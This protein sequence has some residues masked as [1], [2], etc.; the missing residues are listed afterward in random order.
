MEN[1]VIGSDIPW[2]LLQER[3]PEISFLLSI[4]EPNLRTFREDLKKSLYN[5][6]LE[7]EL[8]EWKN[9]LILDGVEVLYVYGVG[10]GYHYLSLKKWLAEKKERMLVF[11]EEDLAVLQELFKLPQGLDLLQNPQVHIELL[12]KPFSW[13]QVLDEAIRK[14][15]SDR[16][17]FTSMISYAKGQEK[18]IKKIRLE[19]LRKSALMCV[20]M[21]E[22]LHYHRLMENISLNFLEV[23][24]SF[25]VN[26]W[27]NICRGVPAI[28]CGAGVS[29]AEAIET[30]K[31]LENKAL[32]IAGGS[33]IT[34]LN[35]VGIRPHIA[36]A[37]DP[38]DEEYARIKASSCFEIPFVYS[39]RLQ[40]EVLTSTNVTSGYL[41]SDTGGAFEKWL[42]D[43]LKIGGDTL[44]PELGIEALSVTT[45]AVPLA[46]YLGCGPIL[47]CGVDLSYKD[48][49]RYPEGVIASAKV[50]LEEMQAEKRSMEKLVR[51]KNLEGQMVYSLVKW[52]MEANCLGSYAKKN[53]GT[54]FFNAS[55]QGLPI[56]S[57]PY[58]SIRDFVRNYCETEYDLRA[59]LHAE[60]EEARVFDFSIKEVKQ[61]FAKLSD[62]LQACLPLFDQMIQEIERKQGL[63][64]DPFSP[65]DSGKMQLLEMDLVEQKAYEICL[66]SVFYIYQ[67]IL[68]RC[69][70]INPIENTAFNQR[71]E[72][73][74]KK[75]LWK[76]CHSVV[77][78]CLK[79]VQSRIAS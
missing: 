42:Q 49:Q 3:F 50:F 48:M 67:K 26:C 58:L 9:S 39:S 2:E 19:L 76:E 52:V 72:L 54:K 74:K 35:H 61:T 51:K 7:L 68:N 73:E 21:T 53:K 24:N 70:P 1:A 15:V 60:T 12:K 11:F 69:Y 29:L 5:Q 78:A 44:G 63:P 65:L 33:A 40:K 41:C 47:L 77:K 59:Q 55:S 16:V 13:K 10:L 22:C 62:S 18:K 75:Q 25:H 4:S 66:D 56:H 8:Q 31:K 23:P 28:I 45:L 37:L 14:W 46:H 32:I 17:E 27:K 6:D 30:I 71:T 57:I 79:V 43:E 64:F 36:I 20:A 34:A 38:N